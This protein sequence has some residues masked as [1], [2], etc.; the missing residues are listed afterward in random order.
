MK[1]LAAEKLLML[2]G[3]CGTNLQRMAIP[4]AAWQ[5]CEGC[6]ELLNVTA[7]DAIVEL[8]R[9]FFDAGAMAVE[10]NTFGASSI[11]LAEYGLQ[12]RVREINTAAVQNARRAAAGVPG[13]YVIG[14]VGPTTKLVSLK[15]ITVD[16]LAAALKEQIVALIDAGVDAILFETCQDLLQIKT[17]L[18]ACFET[19]AER[20]ATLPVMV[21]VTIEQTGTLLVGSD[22]AAV[23]AALEPFPLFS[24]GLNCATGPDAM[25]SPIRYL[26]Q[27]WPRR[28]S[29]IPNQGL[30]EVVNGQTWYP[31]APP[32][33]ASQLK[34]FVVEQGVSV[35]GGCC[36]TTAE[37]IR[38]LVEAV[39]EVEP[40]VRSAEVFP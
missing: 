13:R 36:G 10:T 9:S 11:V 15:H 37:H 1:S 3:A 34:Q 7:P 12:N 26:S 35:I 8:H 14:S 19:L 23:V 33:F 16:A 28:V 30:P 27:N 25:K 6:N 22:I 31:L 40:G 21:S 39:Q 17:A 20:R 38:A 24:L 5:G 18:V 4:D 32:D 2:D 29:C